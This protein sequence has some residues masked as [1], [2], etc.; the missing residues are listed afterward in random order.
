MFADKLGTIAYRANGHVPI[1]KIG[2]G[3]LP[4]PGDSSDYGW[5]GYVP[6]DEL[7]TVINPEESYIATANNEIVGEEYPYYITDFWAQPYRYERIAQLLESKEKLSVQD[8]KDIQ[9]DTVNLYAADFYRILLKHS[10]RLIQQ[11]NIRRLLHHLKLGTMMKQL[12]L[13][14]HLF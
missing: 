6:F 5:E 13:S 2:D 4:V 9:M 3:K 11:V 12:I 10:K 14:K 8:M 1:C 7:P